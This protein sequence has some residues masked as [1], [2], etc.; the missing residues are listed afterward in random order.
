MNT[1]K[2]KWIDNAGLEEAVKAIMEMWKAKVVDYLAAAYRKGFAR[3]PVPNR[4]L[5]HLERR[6]TK[7]WCI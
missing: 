1:G 3:K 5:K 7:D 2:S 6:R 4:F